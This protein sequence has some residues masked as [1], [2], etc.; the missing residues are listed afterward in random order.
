MG[1]ALLAG[2]LDAGWEPESSPWPRS[3][4]T[5]GASLETT[6]AGVHVVPSPAWAVAEADVVVV[7][8]KPTTSSPALESAA[9]ALADGRHDPLD[10][11][12]RHAGDARGRAPGP[13]GRAR[14]AEHARARPRGRRRRSPAGSHA[15]D[16]DLELAERVLGAVGVVVR[17]PENAARRRHGPVGLGSGV[18]VPPRRGDDRSRGARRAA[19]ATRRAHPRAT[20][21]CSAR[22]ACSTAGDDRPSRCAP[23]SPHPAAPPRPAWLELEAHGLPRPRCSKRYAPPPSVR[24]SSAAEPT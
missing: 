7:A 24:A 8:V 10:R 17:V 14:D 13:R 2:L 11:G 23:R 16:A 12:R 6:F 18:R 22:V 9:P 1:E 21:R 15:T 20:R 19:R 4:P 3:T 5:A